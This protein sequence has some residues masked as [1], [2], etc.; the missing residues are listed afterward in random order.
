M[1]EELERI[2]IEAMGAIA[3]AADVEALNEVRVRYLGKKGAL[4]QVLRG[5]GSLPAAE[6]PGLGQL[7]NETRDVIEGLLAGRARE[8]G[9]AELERRLEAERID[10]TL[11]GQRPNLG[12]EHPLRLILE[13]IEDIFLGLGYEI[14]E[15]P[16]V[17]SDHYNFT[18]LNIPPDHPARGMHDTFYVNEEILLRT[19]TSPVQVRYMQRKAPE[20]P[21][22]IIAPGRVYRR[23]DDA[24]H[25]P[26]FEQVEILAVDQGITMADLKGTLLTFARQMFGRDR[27]IRLRPSYFPFTEPSAEVDVSCIICGGSG[28]RV[29]K[30]T[31][32]LEILGCGM[33][34][35]AVLVNGGY[36]PSRVTGFAAGM[37]V[38]RIAM[39]KYG[40]DD[41]R[42]FF[43][44]DVRF[45]RQF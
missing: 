28:C 10:V 11:P 3:A 9:E 32:W 36:D 15:G 22:K 37:G 21:V 1:R 39:L 13:E 23:D 45:L 44:N 6:R 25:S 42:H 14:A 33:V 35:P 2:R 29:C 41:L 4:T 8:L 34:H 17:E 31:G 24:T 38:E 43:T 27:E 16:E 19:H 20:L 26:M 40:V 12:R 18:L 30:N 5:M 7:A